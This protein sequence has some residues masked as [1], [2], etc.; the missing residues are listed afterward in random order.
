MNYCTEILIVERHTLIASGLLR[1][2]RR[3]MPN[4]N[5]MLATSLTEA[6]EVIKQQSFDLVIIYLHP[7]HEAVHEAVF[8][9]IKTIREQCSESM[10][11]LSAS[12][13]PQ[14]FTKHLRNNQVNALFCN[15][16]EGRELE[17]AMQHLARH[18]SYCSEVF[19]AFK[20]KLLSNKRAK[21]H[22]KDLPTKREAEVLDHIVQGEKTSQIALNLGISIN[23]VETHRKNLIQKVGAQNVAGLV[24][25]SIA[26]GWVEVNKI[27]LK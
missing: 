8:G 6:E 17:I 19:A 2:V 13:Y 9:L 25:R 16:G 3:I 15:E 20:L 23:T 7:I 14:M 24:F 27:K 5:I 21:T 12:N 1:M 10:I 18:E 11:L 22:K 26:A 4:S